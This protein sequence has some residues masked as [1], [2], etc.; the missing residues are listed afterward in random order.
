MA[1]RLVLLSLLA[2]WAPAAS[3]ARVRTVAHGQRYA[4]FAIR[5]VT[6]INGNGT[7]ARGP[8]DVVVRAARAAQGTN[9]GGRQ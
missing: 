1:R 2:A 3:S 9:Q 4:R 5:N 7:P 6:I 8:A